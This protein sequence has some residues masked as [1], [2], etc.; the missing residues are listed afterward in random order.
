LYKGEA[1]VV[2]DG[3]RV[4]AKP[5]QDHQPHPQPL[6]DREGSG[7]AQGVTAVSVL[8]GGEMPFSTLENGVFSARKRCFHSGERVGGIV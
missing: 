3:G 8:P 7:C 1:E 2:A 5:H 6:P 4:A